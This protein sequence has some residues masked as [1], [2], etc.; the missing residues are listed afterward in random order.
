MGNMSAHTK[1][2][3]S[4]SFKPTRPFKIV[5][6]V[7]IHTHRSGSEDYSVNLYSGPPFKLETHIKVHN[8]FVN[9]VIVPV[10]LK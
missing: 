10:M 7:S 4:V 6:Y 2:C 9:K 8:N 5:V 1:S 3:N